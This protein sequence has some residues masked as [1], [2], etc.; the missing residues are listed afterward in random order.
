MLWKSVRMIFL[1]HQLNICGSFCLWRLA[2]P[3]AGKERSPSVVILASVCLAPQRAPDRYNFDKE[4][5]IYNRSFEARGGKWRYGKH[6]RRQLGAATC[7]GKGGTEEGARGKAA[8]GMCACAHHADAH[9]YWMPRPHRR[10]PPRHPP[11]LYARYCFCEGR[12]YPGTPGSIA[13]SPIMDGRG[14]EEKRA[15]QKR[16]QLPN[17][18]REKN[19]KRHTHVASKPSI[20]GSMGEREHSLST[21]CSSQSGEREP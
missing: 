12:I 19:T 21:L 7:R 6:R 20:S 13:L 3:H 9:S 5:N 15:R 2:T 14:E 16:T 18:A 10:E 8:R 1:I 4:M 17:R 11:L